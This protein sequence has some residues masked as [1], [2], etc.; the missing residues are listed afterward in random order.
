MIKKLIYISIFFSLQSI[1]PSQNNFQNQKHSIIET[2]YY[3][4]ETI[5]IQNSSSKTIAIKAKILKHHSITINSREEIN[6]FENEDT[7]HAI[8]FHPEK[9]GVMLFLKIINKK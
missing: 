3:V 1:L 8:I 9:T 6:Q 7:S 2:K 5:D 4:G